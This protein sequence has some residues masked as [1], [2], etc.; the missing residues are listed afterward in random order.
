M[1]TTDPAALARNRRI[2]E[3]LYI[4][5]ICGSGHDGL[6]CGLDR[7]HVT[8]HSMTERISHVP[9][10]QVRTGDVI[11]IDAG[12]WMRVA[13]VAEDT[14]RGGDTVLRIAGSSVAPSKTAERTSY[15]AFP[16]DEVQRWDATSR[17]AD[18]PHRNRSL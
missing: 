5:G 6:Y 18:D 16:S 11:R 13:S 1:I 17:Y 9:A 12:R 4:L 2:R 10:R 3:H 15:A 7:W 8:N 14:I